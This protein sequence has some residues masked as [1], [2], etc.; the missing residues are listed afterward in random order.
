MGPEPELGN[1]VFWFT[2]RHGGLRT[3]NDSF[4]TFLKTGGTEIDEKAQREIE[5]S[6]IGENLLGVNRSQGFSGFQF[7]QNEALD[8][9]VGPKPLLEAEASI[10]DR[11][12]LL[13]FNLEPLLF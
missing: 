7:N 2:R 3:I 1:Q 4:A 5:Q 9:Q 10:S 6:K 8:N 11:N 13:A 12:R